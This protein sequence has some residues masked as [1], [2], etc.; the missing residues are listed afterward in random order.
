MPGQSLQEEGDCPE[1]L[2]EGD[3][4]AV[5]G[6]FAELCRTLVTCVGVTVDERSA[7]SE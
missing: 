2:L 1:L 7:S 6:L 3:D 5:F 4:Q